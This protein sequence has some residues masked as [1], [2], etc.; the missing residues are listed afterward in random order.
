MWSM[1]GFV[2]VSADAGWKRAS[3]PLELEVLVLVNC[4]TYK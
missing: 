3:D 1:C 2:C 4:P